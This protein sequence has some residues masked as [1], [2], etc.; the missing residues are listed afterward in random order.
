VKKAMKKDL[1]DTSSILCIFK[2]I[3]E[4]YP[5][6]YDYIMN[7]IETFLDTKTSFLVLVEKDEFFC[8]YTSSTKYKKGNSYK[9]DDF[10]DIEKIGYLISHGNI[11]IG[12][13][14]LEYTQVYKSLNTNSK[15]TIND[16]ICIGLKIVNL[17]ENK[18]RFMQHVC[19]SLSQL[20]E[21][22]KKIINSLVITRDQIH[23]L[24][25]VN[26]YLEDI[27]TVLYDTIDYIEITE[28]KLKLENNIINISEFMIETTNM[29]ES[30]LPNLVVKLELSPGLPTYIISD[31][32]NLQ[33]FIITLIKRLGLKSIT[34]TIQE[35]IVEKII[36]INIKKENITV[37][38][39]SIFDKISK[40]SFLVKL[41]PIQFQDLMFLKLCDLLT[42]NIKHIDN[43]TLQMKLPTIFLKEV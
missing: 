22:I 1:K 29:L 5:I 33:Q 42:I 2:H 23:V 27:M 19:F 10:I 3:L 25:S 6:K 12:Y 4:T 30:V 26:D 18:Y 7:Q 20:V 41:Y 24:D 13:M 11:K 36:Y 28:D 35:S 37:L 8:N 14:I 39:K 40:D 38:Y 43:N 32:K 16:I 15:K 21:K 17:S 34:F 9:K 31:K